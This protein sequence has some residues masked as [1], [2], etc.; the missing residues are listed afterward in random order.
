MTSTSVRQ[1]ASEEGLP[2]P[3][4]EQ[5]TKRLERK[6]IRA[7][8][9]IR[10]ARAVD[11]M[12]AASGGRTVTWLRSHTQDR[13]GCNPPGIEPIT[14]VEAACELERAARELQQAA[15]AVTVTYIRQ[16]RE[17]SRSWTEI[18]DALDLH[19]AALASDETVADEAYDYALRDIPRVYTDRRFFTW[20]CPVCQQP[21]TDKGP[22][23][24]L[25][26]REEGHAPNCPRRTAE[27]AKWHKYQAE[28]PGRYSG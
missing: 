14:G 18:G 8:A 21:I 9:A 4:N 19:G 25:P 11:E 17:A 7:D 3:E 16:A 2:V 10:I 22:W 23:P 27:L 12:M 15:R 5:A 6:Q 24:E 28:R 20:T 26:K 13:P 1:P